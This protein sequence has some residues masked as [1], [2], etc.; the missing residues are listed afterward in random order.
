MQ[1]AN[2]QPPPR[3]RHAVAAAA[4]H[5]VGAPVPFP[6]T[7]FA[8]QSH[9]H[10]LDINI[11]APSPCLVCHAAPSFGTL[12]PCQ[13]HMCRECLSRTLRGR[14]HKSPRNTD[15]N[16]DIQKAYV[17]LACC[18]TVQL[19]RPSYR[20][21]HHN[22]PRPTPLPASVTPTKI[23]ASR[24]TNRLEIGVPLSVKRSIA[25]AHGGSSPSPAS[26]VKD[27][28]SSTAQTPSAAD[29][30]SSLVAFHPIMHS[31]NA[32]SSPISP[33]FHLEHL[34]ASPSNQNL[35]RPTAPEPMFSLASITKLVIPPR[36]SRLINRPVVKIEGAPGTVSAQAIEAWVPVGSLAAPSA[37]PISVHFALF[38]LE[39]VTFPA[40]VP[41]FKRQSCTFLLELASEA[42][43]D[44]MCAED[45]QNKPLSGQR[46]TITAVDFAGMLAHLYPSTCATMDRGSPMSRPPV[47]IMQLVRGTIEC[48]VIVQLANCIVTVSA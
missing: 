31:N 24:L 13:H 17:C 40:P 20:H 23:P 30:G 3:R 27:S 18:A 33:T 6:S 22:T 36:P 32:Q 16:S 28:G 2:Y 47:E 38:P 5:N 21:A 12:D 14:S 41:M 11:P 19:F 37:R 34:T 42:A 25:S 43:L 1:S 10:V 4:V 8:Q 44:A 45:Q 35:S 48:P 9:Q 46:V 39:P 7:P 29:R 26:H 15:A